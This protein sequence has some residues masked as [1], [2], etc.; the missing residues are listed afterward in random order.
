MPQ[1]IN[2]VSTVSGHVP[3][4]SDLTA[5]EIAVNTA[6]K[7]LFVKKDDG[8][9]VCVNNLTHLDGGVVVAP[10]TDP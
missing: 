1:I 5:G 10:T 7:K 9:V 4:S 8:T 2:K 3:T 6:D